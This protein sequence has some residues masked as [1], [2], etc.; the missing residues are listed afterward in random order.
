M[1]PILLRL[2]L[3]FFA[4]TADLTAHSPDEVAL[5]LSRRFEGERAYFQAALGNPVDLFAFHR[6]LLHTKQSE[7]A[8]AEALSKK[9]RHHAM[10]S[11]FEYRLSDLIGL[12]EGHSP[13]IAF[14]VGDPKGTN[15]RTFGPDPVTGRNRILLNVAAHTDLTALR[16]SLS[17]ELVHT[18]QTHFGPGLLDKAAT[19]GIA[20]FLSGQM[21]PNQ[22]DAQLLMW[23]ADKLKAATDRQ[24]AILKAF[25]ATTQDRGADPTEW[26][27]LHRP[28][29]AVPGAP[30]RCA[31][32]LGFL[33]ARKWYAEHPDQ[34]A[35]GLMEL[36]ATELFRDFQF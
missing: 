27:T 19:E 22:T 6:D 29:Q 23:S 17:H 30:D 8:E 28:L 26:L 36:S 35:K 14:L 31:Y 5:V 7:L 34:G 4:L 1:E 13:A 16:I 32:W 2:D 18:R 10:V 12:R 24:D 33:A 11:E 9:L 20:A 25:H 15:A 3:D 21:V